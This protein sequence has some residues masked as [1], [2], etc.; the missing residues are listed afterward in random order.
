[1]QNCAT[2]QINLEHGLVVNKMAPTVREQS[3]PSGDS[4]FYLI[5]R[6]KDFDCRPTE[7]HFQL[8]SYSYCIGS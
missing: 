1:M 5:Y 6:L 3:V 4:D 2:R 7:C 8:H